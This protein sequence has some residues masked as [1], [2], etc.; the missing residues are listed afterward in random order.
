M[1]L[2]RYIKKEGRKIGKNG[3]YYGLGCLVNTCIE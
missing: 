1:K 2:R 3:I